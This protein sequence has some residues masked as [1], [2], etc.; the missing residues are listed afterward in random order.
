M[1][2]SAKNLHFSYNTATQFIFPDIN[3]NAGEVLIISGKSGTG[4][5][6]LLHLLGGILK[7]ISGQIIIDYT[8]INTLNEKQLDKFRG[9]NIGIVFQKANFISSLNVLENL[10]LASWL[11]TKNKQT[12]KAKKILS[13][14]DLSSHLHKKPTELSVGQQQRVSIARAIINEPKLILADEPTS[15]LDDENCFN[16]ATL[17]SETAKAINAALIIVTHDSRLKDKFPNHIQLV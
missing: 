16:V 7:P 10:E 9:N 6:T 17:L 12:E 8:E 1:M 2:I 11:A 5:T 15:N 13:Q 4:K 3:C 14:L